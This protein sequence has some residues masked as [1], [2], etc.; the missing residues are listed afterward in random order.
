MCARLQTDQA[1]AF[2][3]VLTFDVEA[4]PNARYLQRNLHREVREHVAGT[5][6]VAAA[7]PAALAAL[8]RAYRN[9]HPFNGPVLAGVRVAAAYVD[10]RARTLHLCAPRTSR[11]HVCS[12]NSPAGRS[13]VCPCCE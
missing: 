8:D 2:A 10:L 9:L 1:H 5:G 3:A 12:L 6:D 13:S 7:L 4:Q 11:P